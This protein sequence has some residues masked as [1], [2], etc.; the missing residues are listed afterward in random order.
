[1]A[2]LR[3]PTDRFHAVTNVLAG[4]P[5]PG[6]SKD[7]TVGLLAQYNDLLAALRMGLTPAKHPPRRPKDQPSL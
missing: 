2:N 4:A 3:N 1:M 7:C 6:P 5:T